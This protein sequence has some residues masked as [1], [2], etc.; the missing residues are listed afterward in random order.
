MDLRGQLRGFLRRPWTRAKR[1][2]AQASA[3]SRLRGLA[4]SAAKTTSCLTAITAA[5][6]DERWGGAPTTSSATRD[7]T[8]LSATSSVSAPISCRTP[9]SDW[10]RTSPWS[11]GPHAVSLKVL[12]DLPA[13]RE[14]L[15]DGGP[16]RSCAPQAR[17][18]EGLAAGRVASHQAQPQRRGPAQSKSIPT[19]A[20]KPPSCDRVEANGIAVSGEECSP[21]PHRRAPAART[22]EVWRT[23][24]KL[25]RS[26]AW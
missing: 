14:E 3:C 25:R 5:F 9:L 19:R 22:R 12:L 8:R 10:E 21:S 11:S 6:C 18:V 2:N 16:A 4:L 7:S 20:S 13:H 24:E 15:D 23:Q 17:Q 1:S 26:T